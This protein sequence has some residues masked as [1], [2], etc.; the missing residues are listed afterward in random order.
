MDLRSLSVTMRFGI[1]ARGCHCFAQAPDTDPDQHETYAALAPGRDGLDRQR[2]AQHQRQKP[3]AQDTGAVAESPS[4]A[5]PPGAGLSLSGVRRHR[6]Q[7]IGSRQHMNEAGNQPCE[8]ELSCH[9]RRQHRDLL[10]VTQCPGQKAARARRVAE[11]PVGQGELDRALR[12]V[13]DAHEEGRRV[14]GIGF[15]P[16]RQQQLV[17]CSGTFRFACRLAVAARGQNLRI[18]RAIFRIVRDFEQRHDQ[19]HR[20]VQL[21]ARERHFGAMSSSR[22]VRGQDCVEFDEDRFRAVQIAVAHRAHAPLEQQLAARQWRDA[23]IRVERRCIAGFGGDPSIHFRQQRRERAKRMKPGIVLRQSLAQNQR[24]LL[25]RP[26]R[27]QQRRLF[28]INLVSGIAGRERLIEKGTRFF[29]TMEMPRE[30]S[31][32]VERR[33]GD[34]ATTRSPRWR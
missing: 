19:R 20:A 24:V 21:S 7:V 32:N 14:V 17:R 30:P 31:T 15:G 33:C 23:I 29:E 9:A 12:S 22:N 6:R 16:S 5:R 3:H 1:D 8:Y 11:F 28:G 26:C 13:A 25:Y 18:N 2:I 34:R 27:L 4:N 10:R